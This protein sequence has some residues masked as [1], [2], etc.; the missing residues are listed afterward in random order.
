[1]ELS[2]TEY[3][4]HLT[5]AAR[6]AGLGLEAIA[7]PMER[8]ARLGG[9]RFHYLDWGGGGPAVVFLH[10]GGLTAHTWDLCCLLLH[11]KYRCIALDLRG[12]GDSDWAGDADYSL[13]R[14][15]DDVRTFVDILGLDRFG[16]I[17][18]SLGALTALA[19][20]IEHAGRLNALALIDAGP[21]VRDD[22]ARRIRRFTANAP[23]F[24]SIEEAVDYAHRFNP[25]RDPILLRGSLRYNLRQTADATW[26][27]KHDPRRFDYYGTDA[28]RRDRLS[29]WA[30]ID[31]VDCAAL[32]V[33]GAESRMF[34]EE[35]ASLLAQ[36]LPRAER[37][38]IANAGHTVQG[39]NPKA[40]ATALA[41]FFAKSSAA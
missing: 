40:L 8:Y 25:R 1:M 28:F 12:H 31:R 26:V 10:G 38:T 21:D 11:E 41:E 15:R 30:G 36:R 27:W 16:L 24:R 19:F 39:D 9:M 23:S 4:E 34:L 5:L 35:D 17:G 22:A 3:R 13:P 29:L 33:R 37:V 6:H 20:A 2:E 32:V 14:H 18:M 7:L